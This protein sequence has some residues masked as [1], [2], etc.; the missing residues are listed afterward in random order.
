MC[1]SQ[2]GGGE[3]LELTVIVDGGMIESFGSQRVAITSLISPDER[4]GD[5][6]ER[7]TTLFS[8]GAAAEAL[9]CTVESYKLAY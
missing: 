1:V 4:A 8:E 9:V 6:S 3:L 2:V 5:L 7:A